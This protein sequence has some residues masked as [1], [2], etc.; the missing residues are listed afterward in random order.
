MQANTSSTV[1]NLSGTLG[2]E[3]LTLSTEIDLG[4]KQRPKPTAPVDTEGERGLRETGDWKA[5]Q[6]YKAAGSEMLQYVVFRHRGRCS[7]SAGEVAAELPC[8][9]APLHRKSPNLTT[10]TAAK[11]AGS[12]WE[13][14]VGRRGGG[15][16]AV[17]V[18]VSI[19]AIRFSGS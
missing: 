11:Q 14:E 12:G 2:L 4:L 5:S 6:L 16:R 3:T 19:V 15:R 10:C 9:H 7:R 18:T 1:L 13:G 17:S 8:G